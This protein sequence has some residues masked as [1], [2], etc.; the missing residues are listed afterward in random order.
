MNLSRTDFADLPYFLAVARHRSFSRAGIELGVS[1]SALSHALRTF[2]ER[3]GIRLLNRTTRSVTLTAAGEQLYDAITAP[4]G[5]LSE[6]VDRLNRF[7]DSP[8][9]LIRLNVMQDAAIYLL[10]PVLPTFAERYPD[11]KLDV[12]ANNRMIDVIAEG[13]DAGIR[14][15]GTV[16]E[17]MI[18]QPLSAEIAWVVVGSPGYLKRHGTPTHPSEL[19]NHRCLGIRLGTGHI[20]EWEF[21]RGSESL[22]VSVPGVITVDD[23]AFGRSLVERDFGLFYTTEPSVRALVEQGKLQYVLEDWRSMGPAFHMYYSS[24]RQVPAGLKLLIDLIRELKPLG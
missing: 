24:R 23:G 2:E 20:Y 12:S 3:I 6:A 15:G 9:G 18:A 16:P 21:D 5:A 4:M 8:S 13:F 1:S 22:A 11:I 7:R 10:S 19:R 17:D 14:Y